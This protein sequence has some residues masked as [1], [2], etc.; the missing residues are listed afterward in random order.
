MTDM[1]LLLQLP[2]AGDDLQAIKKGVMELADLVVVNKADLDPAAAARAV[3]Q[4]ESALQLSR[5]R[6]TARRATPAGARD[7]AR[8][9][10]DAGRTPSGTPPPF[11]AAQR[12]AAAPSPARRQTPGA[13]LAAGADRRRPAPSVP[14]PPRGPRRCSPETLAAVDAGRL[15]VSVAARTL[16]RAFAGRAGRGQ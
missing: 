11:R 7:A 2:N 9:I 16:L 14:R 5:I 10:R 15:P 8:S 4:I 13:R 1:F 3:G 6:A 12:R